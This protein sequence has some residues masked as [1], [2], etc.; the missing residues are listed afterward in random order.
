M[1][2]LNRYR[3]RVQFFRDIVLDAKNTSEASALAEQD[4]AL[5][6][7]TDIVQAQ[8]VTLLEENTGS[9]N[10]AT[11]NRY[12]VATRIR[13]NVVTDATDRTNARQLAEDDINLEND[14]R[15]IQPQQT[16]VLEEGVG[17]TE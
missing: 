11:L 17:S 14:A 2:I 16:I 5:A 15:N 3:V 6:G 1:A 12:S 8:G 9:D 7:D 4:A 10:G 13:R